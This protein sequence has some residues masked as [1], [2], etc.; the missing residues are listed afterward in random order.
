MRYYA[1]VMDIKLFH[2]LKKIGFAVNII[3]GTS[4]K[5]FLG[6]ECSYPAFIDCDQVRE[7]VATHANYIN[8]LKVVGYALSKSISYSPEINPNIFTWLRVP[9]KA[10]Y[11]LIKL[12]PQTL[13]NKL[14]IN[15]R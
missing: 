6:S 8:K 10:V 12:A 2:L 5:F 4:G 3:K 1:S 7:D 13:I 9:E 15:K 11:P 14:L